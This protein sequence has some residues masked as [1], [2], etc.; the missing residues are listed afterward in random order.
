M[1]WLV[2]NNTPPKTKRVIIYEVET[3]IITGAEYL[4]NSRN[5]KLGFVLDSGGWRYDGVLY[6]N[7]EK[8]SQEEISDPGIYF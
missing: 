6:Q 3:D 5:G 7:I 4:K 8:P 2:A 1:G